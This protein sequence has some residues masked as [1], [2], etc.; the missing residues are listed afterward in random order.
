MSSY[1]F[2][3]AFNFHGPVSRS[4]KWHEIQPS[5]PPQEAWGFSGNWAACSHS[6][7]GLWL[8]WETLTGLQAVVEQASHVPTEAWARPGQGLSKAGRAGGSSMLQLCWGARELFVSS[9][10]KE[11]RSVVQKGHWHSSESV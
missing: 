5:Q 10:W 4:E 11:L 7:L 6:V 8:C 9:A 1:G 3:G 2:G